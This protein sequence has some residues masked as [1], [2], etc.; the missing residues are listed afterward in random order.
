LSLATTT[1]PAGRLTRRIL[2]IGGE[3][4]PVTPRLSALLLALPAIGGSLDA[5]TFLRMITALGPQVEQ[6]PFAV[7]LMT[8]FGVSPMLA[9]KGLSVFIAWRICLVI[10]KRQPGLAIA[11]AL[12]IHDLGLFGAFTNLLSVPISI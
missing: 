6:N 3:V 10:A 1:H 5:I 7:W 12:I 9:L 2:F 8:N 11:T 4:R